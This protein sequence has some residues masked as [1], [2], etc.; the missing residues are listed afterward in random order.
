MFHFI[1]GHVSRERIL[2]EK[3]RKQCVETFSP[4]IYDNESLSF[5]R[6]TA[7]PSYIISKQPSA[8]SFNKNESINM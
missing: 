5:F 8:C 2:Q 1:K 6:Q 7:H 4:R 3:N